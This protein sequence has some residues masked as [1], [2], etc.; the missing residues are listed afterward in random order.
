[1]QILLFKEKDCIFLNVFYIQLNFVMQKLIVTIYFLSLVAVEC[2]RINVNLFF[3][4][5]V[6]S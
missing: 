1:M 4:F 3:I 2:S 6:N 5:Q